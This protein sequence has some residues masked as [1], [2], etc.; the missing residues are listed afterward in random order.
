MLAV[1][2]LL[3][4]RLNLNSMQTITQF[5]PST[6]WKTFELL[7]VSLMV[8]RINLVVAS[9][10]KDCLLTEFFPGAVLSG[11]K[12]SL[13]LSDV[14]FTLGGIY[15]VYQEVSQWVSNTFVDTS[16]SFKAFPVDVDQGNLFEF[17][18]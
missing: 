8:T 17:L 9:G 16:S 10:R 13:H 12:Q 5:P 2:M 15:R 6:D 18:A 11:T 3:T 4:F 14:R 1:L 7:C